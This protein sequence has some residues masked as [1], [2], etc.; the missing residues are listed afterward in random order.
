MHDERR[1]LMSGRPAASLQKPERL[2]RHL[3]RRRRLSF[4]L[5]GVDALDVCDEPAAAIASVAAAIATAAKPPAA[6]TAAAAATT[7]T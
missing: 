4:R 3:Q 5:R 7:T 2:R 6:I 1:K